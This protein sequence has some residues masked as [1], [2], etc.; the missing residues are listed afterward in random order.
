[1]FRDFGIA[2]NSIDRQP[3]R[4]QHFGRGHP[5]GHCNGHREKGDLKEGAVK[6]EALKIALAT[7][8]GLSYRRIV[9]RRLQTMRAAGRRA[10]ERPAHWSPSW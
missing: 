3:G 6:R 7:R 8:S 2:V 1:M 10:Q 5:R 9:Q 4:L